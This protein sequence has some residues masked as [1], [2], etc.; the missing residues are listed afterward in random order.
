[1]IRELARHRMY[2]SVVRRS[3]H[4]RVLLAI[5]GIWFTAALSEAPG[6]H[7][8]PVHGGHAAHAGPAEHLAHADHS[9]HGSPSSAPTGH[10]RTRTR[11]RTVLPLGSTPSFNRAATPVAKKK[12]RQ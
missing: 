3:V 9:A 2:Y 10:S 6:L 4:V 1:M 8:C 5:W 11:S 7:A 12:A